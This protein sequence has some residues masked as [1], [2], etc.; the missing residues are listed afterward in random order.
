MVT[1]VPPTGHQ[2]HECTCCHADAQHIAFPDALGAGQFVLCSSCTDENWDQ[3][4]QAATEGLK[5]MK[6]MLAAD[7]TNEGLRWL[8][9]YGR[10]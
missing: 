6:A 10:K 9:F 1:K 3:R 5:Q 8:V 2:L 7:P 4:K